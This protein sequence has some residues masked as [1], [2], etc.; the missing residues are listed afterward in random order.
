MMKLWRSATQQALSLSAHDRFRAVRYEDLIGEPKATLQNLCAEL[1]LEYVEEMT[2]VPHWGSSTVE[3]SE[4]AGLS[5]ASIDKWQTVLNA[6][7]IAYC[8]ARSKPEREHFGYAGS[9][10]SQSTLPGYIGMALRLPVH[11]LGAVLANPGRVLT[12]V[13]AI[14]GRKA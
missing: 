12:I 6:A 14:F 5:S 10:S 7:E 11:V 13:R 4:S 8:E 1:D 3:H 2:E 9:D